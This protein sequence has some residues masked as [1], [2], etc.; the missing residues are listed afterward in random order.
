MS[1]QH[2]YVPQKRNIYRSSYH[3]SP[4]L[5][6]EIAINAMINIERYAVLE[7]NI[8]RHILRH[9]IHLRQFILPPNQAF[10]TS[11]EN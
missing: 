8:E 9:L 4:L 5:D 10:L 3:L 1:E 2:Q 7:L 6:K 11:D